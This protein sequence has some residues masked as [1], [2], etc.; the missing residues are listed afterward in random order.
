MAGMT[1]LAR[2]LRS[3]EPTVRGGEFVYVNFSSSVIPAALR[4]EAMI[5]E[6]DG[7]T[8]ILHRALLARGCRFDC[9][10]FR[11][12]RRRRY[13][14]QRARW[15]SSRPSARASEAARCRPSGPAGAS[16][17]GLWPG[18]GERSPTRITTLLDQAVHAEE[19]LPWRLP[20]DR[21]VV[22]EVYQGAGLR[23]VGQLAV[24]TV[25]VAELEGR[26]LSA[27][28]RPS[29]REATACDA[30]T[31]SRQNSLPSMS[32]MVMQDSLSS[33]AG[34]SRTR[35]APSATSRAHSASS[36]ARRSS[37]TSPVPARTSR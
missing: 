20:G 6:D 11:S 1:D 22:R 31:Q 32:C 26:P 3:L 15:L 13:K 28:G 23:G 4:S 33:S 24:S 9:R 30:A 12:A 7:L 2:M 34:S 37:P 35:T 21:R 8:V 27:R 29:L 16:A 18:P 5:R 10:I 14:L 19:L 25:R 36:V 17:I